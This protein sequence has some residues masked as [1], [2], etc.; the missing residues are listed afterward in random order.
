MEHMGEDKVCHYKR[1]QHYK[2]VVGRERRTH[3]S[4]GRASLENGLEMRERGLLES[5]CYSQESMATRKENR[6]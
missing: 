2:S 5:A 4:G 3:Q 1:S 6:T